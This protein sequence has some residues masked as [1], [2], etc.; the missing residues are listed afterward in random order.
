VQ[1]Y[2]EIWA[3]QRAH[4]LVLAVYRVSANFPSDER[5]G[6]TSQIRRAAM[7]VPNN[8]A[9]GSK[10]RSAAD[11]ARFINMSEGSLSEAD[12]L[13]LLACD[14]GFLPEGDAKTLRNECDEI[15]RMLNALHARILAGADSN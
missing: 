5:F 11:Y 8:I 15:G 7:S 3:W 12:Y 1:R 10:R 13:L 9:E 6:L 4:K 2:T 14:L